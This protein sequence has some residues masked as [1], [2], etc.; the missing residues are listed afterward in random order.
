MSRFLLIFSANTCLTVVR[1]NKAVLGRP[2]L[3]TLRPSA[4]GSIISLLGVIENDFLGH[5][6]QYIG[7]D[8]PSVA[9][10]YVAPIVRWTLLSIGLGDE[11]GLGK[12]DFP[13]VHSW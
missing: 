8:K 6:G 10:V 7:G 4:L 1:W 11:A 9:D 13:R 5:G 12:E 3:D 2:D